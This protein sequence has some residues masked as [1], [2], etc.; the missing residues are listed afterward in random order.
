MC[1]WGS[2]SNNPASTKIKHFPNYST[3][4]IEQPPLSPDQTENPLI[5]PRVQT[6]M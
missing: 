6:E 2:I 3:I 1:G 5:A 4:Q